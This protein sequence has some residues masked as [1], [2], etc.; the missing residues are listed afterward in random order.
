MTYHATLAR[1]E[2][3]KDGMGRTRTL[4][5]DNLDRLTKTT[6]SDGSSVENVYDLDG[7]LLKEID[8]AGGT[9]TYTYD[10][11]G[12]LEHEALPGGKSTAY[13]YDAASNLRSLTDA[14]GK[15]EYAYDAV[16]QQKAVFEPGVGTPTRFVYDKD[17][18]RT[19]TTYPNGVSIAM[20]YDQADRPEEITST[21]AGAASPIQKLLY[22]YTSATGREGLLRESVT[23][24]VAKTKTEYGYDALD[25]LR[26]ARTASLADPAT[27]LASYEYLLD[28]ASNR[29][30]QTITGT[31]VANKTTSYAY[32]D[33]N[34]L[35]WR[36][37]G[38]ITNPVCATPP[39]GTATATYDADGNQTNDAA[40]RTATY[41]LRDQ[42]TSLTAGGTTSTFGYLGAGQ[43]TWTS[44]GSTGF[45]HNALGLAAGGSTYWTRDEGGALVSQRSPAGRHYYLF[46]ALGSVTGLT[47]TNGTKVR[48]YSYDPYG[49]VTRSEGTF[50]G[51]MR[52]AGGYQGPGG[53]YHYGQR[54]YDPTVGRWTQPDPLDQTGDMREGNRYIYAAADPINLSDLSGLFSIGIDVELQAG[55]VR[56]SGGVSIDDD[57]NYGYTVGAGGGRSVGGGFG[58]GVKGSANFGGKVENGGSIEGG[59]CAGGVCASADTN[60]TSSVGVGAGMEAG[61]SYRETRRVG[62]L[63]D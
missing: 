32:N 28:G 14:G 54:R 45:Q 7:N 36:A 12:R 62:N 10:Q 56:F 49:N 63:W 1:I 8:S 46:D 27:T 60:G 57:G 41:N 6:Y 31:Q 51:A 20:R 42:T 11:L 50:D 58:G 59:G 61:I 53:L 25:R 34:Q 23:D 47:D 17:G 55:P 2:S 26:I 19:K 30:R 44:I 39:A 5:Y 43:A 48:D 9:T 21:Q 15:V 52:Y 37:P 35:C 13:T 24:D 16:N 29:E 4:S 33:A 3:V 40:G 18:K 22:S 38:A